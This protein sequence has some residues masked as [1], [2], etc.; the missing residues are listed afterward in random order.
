MPNVSIS[1]QPACGSS[2]GGGEGGDLGSSIILVF[3]NIKKKREKRERRKMS[4]LERMFYTIISKK[5]KKDTLPSSTLNKAP[6]P[7]LSSFFFPCR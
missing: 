4:V 7:F 6:T 2:S 3:S 5:G 1:L